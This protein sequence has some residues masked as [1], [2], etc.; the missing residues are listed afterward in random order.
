MNT[1]EKLTKEHLRVIKK[2]LDTLEDIQWLDGVPE[3]ADSYE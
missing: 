3:G 2:A 1:M